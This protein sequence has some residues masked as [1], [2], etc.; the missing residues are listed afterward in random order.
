MKK[1]TVKMFARC[2]FKVIAIANSMGSEHSIV[3]TSTVKE[4]I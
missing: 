3:G 2:N 1:T 4:Y